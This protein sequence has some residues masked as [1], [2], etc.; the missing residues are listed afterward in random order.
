MSSANILNYQID[1]FRRVMDE[2][3]RN[4]GQKIVFI[5]GKGDGVL[6]HALS[7]ELNYRYKGCRAEDA[8]FARY[9]YGATE[10]TIK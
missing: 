8:S 2:N 1:T 3:L 7:K 6:R 10:V 5:H 4:H 9:G